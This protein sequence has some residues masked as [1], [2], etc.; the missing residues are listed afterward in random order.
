MHSF[1]FPND[2]NDA[3]CACKESDGEAEGNA[4][5][6]T[7]G[8]PD[9]GAY[10]KQGDGADDGPDDKADDQGSGIICLLKYCSLKHS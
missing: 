4:D 8:K 2:A 1:V 9:D 5:D 7:D 10:V 3:N 6:G